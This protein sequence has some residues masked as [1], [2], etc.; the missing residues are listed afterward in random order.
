MYLKY[1]QKLIIGV[2]LL[3]VACLIVSSVFV[4]FEYF[5]GEEVV[6][7]E[8][9]LEEI[10]DRIS[11]L[12]TQAV[13]FELNRIRRKGIIDHM[14]NAGS[15]IVDILPIKNAKIYSILEGL[16]PGIGWRKKPIFDYVIVLD[17]YEWRTTKEFKTWDTD[18]INNEVFRRVEEEKPQVEIEF[19]II[20]IEKKLFRQTEKEAESFHIIYDFKTGRWEGDDYFNDSDGY[21][22][23]NGSNFE[24]WFNVRQTDYD[25]DGIPYWTEVNVLET[26]PKVNDLN[27]DPDLDGIPTAW[28]WK[29]GYDPF[30]FEN[31]TYLDPDND[32]LQNVE[33]WF[34]AE[35]LANPF[36]PDIYIEA[37][38]MERTPLR[39]IEIRI[40]RGRIL[41]ITRPR[42][43]KTNYDG[44]ENVFQ[45]EAQQMLMERFNEHGIT[46]HID[47]GCMGGGGE[48]I[49]FIPQG[50]YAQETGYFSEYYKNNFADDRKGIFRYLI[51]AHGGGF[52]YPNDYKHYYDFMT[53]PSSTEFFAKQLYFGITQRVRR[54]GRA[55]QVMHELGHTCGYMGN[56]SGG[57]DNTSARYGNPPDFPWND[58]VSC[59]NYDYF[60]LRYFDYSDGSHGEHDTNDW[61]K[62]DIGFFQ[63]PSIEM[64][65]LG[66]EDFSS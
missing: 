46:V 30:T 23:F 66:G 40:E 43:V 27:L 53:T 18:Y 21:G 25:G 41:P 50:A 60:A 29:W 2:T 45:E 34:M 65:G 42:L 33:E 39:P 31:H 48:E 58:Y 13:F 57:V 44:S 55:I 61:E 5:A 62:I 37:D 51:T 14:M 36:N 19:K 9:V 56:H 7:D 64:E 1:K 15:N 54:I 47:D 38:Y 20:D 59:M 16:R 35:W 28:E 4:Y 24:I 8:P 63:R 11:P 12:T 26:D 49:P 22:H 17:E 3:V 6:E 10:D 32:G 52:A